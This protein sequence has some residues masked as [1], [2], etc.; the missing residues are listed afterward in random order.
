MQ[1]SRRQRHI[2]ETVEMENAFVE[3]TRPPPPS[4]PLACP[5]G[6]QDI[7]SD[8]ASASFPESQNLLVVPV[9]EY[10]TA[11]GGFKKVT[12]QMLV[13]PGRI[14]IPEHIT[15]SLVLYHPETGEIAARND[16]DN[17]SH[18]G[19]NRLECEWFNSLG[20]VQP[21]HIEMW[22]RPGQI[23]PEFLVPKTDG[24]YIPYCR[25]P[26]EMFSFQPA[27]EVPES[28][29]NPNRDYHSKPGTGF[30][31]PQPEQVGPGQQRTVRVQPRFDCTQSAFIFNTLHAESA[32]AGPNPYV[33]D[34][35]PLSNDQTNA[36]SYNFDG[37]QN[38]QSPTNLNYSQNEA[39]VDYSNKDWN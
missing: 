32:H 37:Y 28:A 3:P 7:A 36:P 8:R 10:V 23:L 12:I 5:C 22:S 14:D 29:I 33:P 11:T 26:G 16:T 20:K 24:N 30:Y 4:A 25:I 6:C 1:R 9:D 18:Y 31:Y 35:I 34:F 38:N 13:T 17:V 27:P 21:I 2:K 39:D 19:G 15:T